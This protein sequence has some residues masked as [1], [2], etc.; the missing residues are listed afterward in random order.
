MVYDE[1]CYGEVT[2]GSLPGDVQQRLL[3]LPGEWLEY[4]GTSG[5]IV[6]RHTEPT[7]PN[8]PT[9]VFELVQ[10]L[11]TIPA[12]LQSVI[13]GGD[14]FV[15]VEHTGEFVR[16]HV[17]SGGGL[18]I[19]WAHPSFT[20]AKKRAYSGGQVTPIEPYVQRL[21]GRVTL[22]VHDPASA[23]RELQ[24]LAD[25]FEG[26][27]PEG[28]YRTTADE[29]AGTVRVEMQDVNLDSQVLVDRLERLA[30]PRSLSGSVVVSA[31]GEPQPEHGIRFLFENGEIWLQRPLMWQE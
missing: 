7:S 8:L 4:D 26:L 2:L 11:S 25:T 3:A 16:L 19:N 6:V 29:S 1:G 15:H 24:A 23:A 14:F 9:I 20:R 22:A 31:F 12:G 28:E 10:M 27:Y 5:R 30:K 13:A 21:N 17:E 18:H